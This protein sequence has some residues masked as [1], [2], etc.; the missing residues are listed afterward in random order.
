MVQKKSDQ[1]KN[2]RDIL[3]W[4][5]GRF[6]KRFSEQ[7][8]VLCC[9]HWRV[10][11]TLLYGWK[12]DADNSVLPYV[13]VLRSKRDSRPKLSISVEEPSSRVLS[14]SCS[15]LAWPSV[16]QLPTNPS[17]TRWRSARSRYL[18]RCICQSQKVRIIRNVLALD[19]EICHGPQELR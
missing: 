16:I 8:L 17:A 5:K 19:H 14:M 2:F 10:V 13:K 18:R 12:F 3:F 7:V 1:G 15:K 11:A 9:R 4:H 6:A